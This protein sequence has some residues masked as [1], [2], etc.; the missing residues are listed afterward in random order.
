MNTS[1]SD[2]GCQASFIAATLAGI[3]MRQEGS[4]WKHIS[5]THPYTN[6][7]R[8]ALW[9]G[10]SACHTKG[11]YI[12]VCTR[13]PAWQGH[14]GILQKSATL[15]LTFSEASFFLSHINTV[16]DVWV[17]EDNSFCFQ[18]QML[19]STSYYKECIDSVTQLLRLKGHIQIPEPLK[20]WPPFNKVKKILWNKIMNTNMAL[21]E[22]KLYNRSHI[23]E[24]FFFSKVGLKPNNVTKTQ[25]IYWIINSACVAFSNV[26]VDR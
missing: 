26:T 25:G 23:S 17:H 18:S 9:A 6:V 2:S 16:S 24:M 4:C 12:R 7:P 8:M 10:T 5:R 21:A 11:I 1:F 13:E 15:K 14:A 19:N 22:I 3:Q 20:S